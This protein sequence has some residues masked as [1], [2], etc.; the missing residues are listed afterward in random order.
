[1]YF[2]GLQISFPAQKKRCFSGTDLPDL[3]ESHLA[4]FINF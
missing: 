3:L 4:V 1:M 2:F